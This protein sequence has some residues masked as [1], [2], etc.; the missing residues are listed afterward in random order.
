MYI[1]EIGGPCHLPAVRVAAD[2]E[3]PAIGRQLRKG[4]VAGFACLPGLAGVARQ[5][6]G[7]ADADGKKRRCSDSERRKGHSNR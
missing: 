4:G 6:F 2:L 7:R 5:G 3:A 1:A